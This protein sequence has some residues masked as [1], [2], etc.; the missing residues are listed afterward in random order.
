M[1]FIGSITYGVGMLFVIPL[2]NIILVVAYRK[3]VYSHQDVDDDLAET[4]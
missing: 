2:V 4:K 3:L 1:V